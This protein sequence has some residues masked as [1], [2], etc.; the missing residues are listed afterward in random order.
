MA[1][2]GTCVPTLGFMTSLQRVFAITYSQEA[3]KPLYATLQRKSVLWYQRIDHL[4]FLD[5]GTL[6]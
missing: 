5:E 2:G 4:M 6:V 1:G 3:V